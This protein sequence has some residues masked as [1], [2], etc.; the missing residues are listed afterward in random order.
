MS[1][2]KR[3][4]YPQSSSPAPLPA[5][6]SLPSML[7]SCSAGFRSCWHTG[8]DIT[9]PVSQR[10]HWLSMMV[11]IPQNQSAWSK[12]RG[13]GRGADHKFKLRPIKNIYL[14]NSGTCMMRSENR[15]R[16]M[17][18][19]NMNLLVYLDCQMNGWVS[20]GLNTA[21]CP[22]SRRL[23]MERWTRCDSVQAL[24]SWQ[25][26][27][28][29][30]GSNCG[31]WSLVSTLPDEEPIRPLCLFGFLLRLGMFNELI[32]EDHYFIS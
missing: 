2:C 18:A 21:D 10:Y 20:I 22:V 24:V 17:V 16:L 28:W 11:Y 23:M 27:A 19:K 26:E 25:P 1:F 29:T 3:S 4:D 12:G 31:R 6:P 13:R 5:A 9:I 14:H 8:C 15:Y 30:G 7:Q 32:I